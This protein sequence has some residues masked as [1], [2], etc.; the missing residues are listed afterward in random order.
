MRLG[1]GGKGG[2]EWKRFHLVPATF[3]GSKAVDN[4]ALLAGVRSRIHMPA[5]RYSMV[6]SWLV[7][8]I[9]SA[10]MARQL[11]SKA[12]A[13]TNNSLNYPALM[14]DCKSCGRIFTLCTVHVSH[15]R[16][17]LELLAGRC[18]V[19]VPWASLYSCALHFSLLGRSNFAGLQ[20]LG[21]SD[22][23]SCQDTG[24]YNRLCRQMVQGGD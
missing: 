6:S 11:L 19:S 18:R 13:Y 9:T 14:F 24:S 5:I 17:S 15:V 8:P 2:G 7:R 21:E 1:W 20:C 10:N 12:A 3:L 16:H 23:Q 4:R 22:R